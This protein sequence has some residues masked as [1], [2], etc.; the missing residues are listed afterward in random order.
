MS[1]PKPIRLLAMR[2]PIWACIHLCLTACA[3]ELNWREVPIAPPGLTVLMPDRPSEMTRKLALG[4]HMMTMH[5]TGARVD[6][7]M[8]TVTVGS[9][10]D[11]AGISAANALA[12][13]EQAML[14]N[15]QGKQLA[16]ETG[17]LVPGVS[18]L[19]LKAQGVAQGLPITMWAWFFQRG[20]HV[21]QAVVI[22]KPADE[23]H[24][25]TFLQSLK[26]SP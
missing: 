18:V 14:R 5:M 3:P 10:E 6:S 23:E 16:R 15:I 11:V 13:M 22:A 24:A 20:M 4:E 2:L 17:E 12:L 9:L 8:F 25:L 19:R 1:A 21:V 26:L 7:R